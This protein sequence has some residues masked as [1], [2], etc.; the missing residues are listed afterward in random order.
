MEAATLIPL[1][2]AGLAS[3]A[4]LLLG[5]GV[6][7]LRR[8]SA[9]SAVLQEK[10]ARFAGGAP[11]QEAQAPLL[12]RF[13]ARV[14]LLFQGLGQ[15]LGPKAVQGGSDSGDQV[16]Q[17]LM[18]A[19]LRQPHAL[20]TFHGVKAALSLLPPALFLG[21][22]LLLPKT[23]GLQVMVVGALFLALAGSYAPNVW[24]RGKVAERRNQLLCELP[25]ALDLMVVCVESGMGLDQAINRVSQELQASAPGISGEFRTMTREMRAG[26]QRQ[27]SLKDLAERTGLEDVQSLVTLLVQA[28]LFGISVARTLRV[29]SDTLRTGRFQRAEERAAKLPTKLMF[30]LIMCI[31]PALFVVIMGPAA[32]QLMQVFSRM[33][34]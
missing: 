22:C 23:P 10:I 27:Q 24:L 29:Y 5:L 9:Q 3:A 1:L 6:R 33:G 14:A 28:D 13:W 4:V 17:N 20:Q 15:L 34:Q 2:G 32:I 12:A 7:N 18:R 19:G 11:G 21:V 16:R 25:D 8:D 31:F 26:R 30:P